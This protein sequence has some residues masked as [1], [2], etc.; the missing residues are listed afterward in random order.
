MNSE[1]VGRAIETAAP[2]IVDVSSGVEQ[3]GLK[4]FELCRNFIREVRK[5]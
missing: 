4:S 1:N 3:D 2:D 5:P